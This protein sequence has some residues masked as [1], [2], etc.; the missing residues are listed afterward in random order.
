MQNAREFEPRR[1]SSLRNALPRDRDD[2]GFKPVALPALVAAVRV[3]ARPKPRQK[4]AY[5]ELPA[6]LRQEPRTD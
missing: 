5:H 2:A 1:E 4:P 3:T 6:I